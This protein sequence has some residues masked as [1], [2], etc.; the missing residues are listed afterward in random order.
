MLMHFSLTASTR[1]F[2]ATGTIGASLLTFDLVWAAALW[3]AI[4]VAIVAYARQLTRQPLT[5]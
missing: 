2:M 5:R 1:I 3:L 4:A